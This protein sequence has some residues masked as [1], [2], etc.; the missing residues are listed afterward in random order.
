MDTLP[1]D[2]IL[3]IRR[4]VIT[5]NRQPENLLCDIRDYYT[6]KLNIIER[7]HYVWVEQM[8][9]HPPG[10]LDYLVHDIYYYLNGFRE[11]Y[12]TNTN[13]MIPTR[14]FGLKL[15][16]LRKRSIESELNILWGRLTPGQR[17]LL[18]KSR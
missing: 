5:L 16:A 9:E 14:F 4:L 11:I 1:L 10:H 8:E 7:Y 15:S 3:R 17:K 13:V 6:T 18:R 2:L 12:Y